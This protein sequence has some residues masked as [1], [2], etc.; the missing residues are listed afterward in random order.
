MGNFAGTL[1]NGNKALGTKDEFLNLSGHNTRFF[2]TE[3]GVKNI[4]Q[5]VVGIQLNLGDF[6]LC[7]PNPQLVFPEEI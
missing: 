1:L 6:S 7:C 3:R 4:D 5:K 2:C